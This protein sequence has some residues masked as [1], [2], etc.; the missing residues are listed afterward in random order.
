MGEFDLYFGCGFFQKV[1][2]NGRRF[3]GC[4]LLKRFLKTDSD[5]PECFIFPER[6]KTCMLGFP[7]G[8]AG[9]RVEL[10]E[11]SRK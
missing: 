5:H 1:P 8:D 3:F 11:K 6:F 2:E 7:R 10:G 4:G 9:E